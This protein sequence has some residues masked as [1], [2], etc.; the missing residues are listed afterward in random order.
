MGA[1]SLVAGRVGYS[2]VTVH[3]LLIAV[4][5]LVWSVGSRVFR[6]QWLWHTHS[7]VAAPERYSTG[8]IVL[9]YQSPVFTTEPPGKPVLGL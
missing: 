4:A 7:E 8:S 6:L 9:V 5:S 2:L 3:G 1:F